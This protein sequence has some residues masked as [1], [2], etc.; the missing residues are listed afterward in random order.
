[1]KINKIF[2]IVLLAI[3]TATLA[4]A[5]N[6]KTL[7]GNITDEV[8]EPVI[9]AN[10]ILVDTK[11]GTISD[12]NGNFVLSNIPLESK[13]IRITYI[14]YVEQ[15]IDISAKTNIT[16]K[17]VPDQLQLNDFVVVG[18][19]SQKKAHVTGAIA[20][21]SPE[22]I[23][24]LSGPSLAMSLRGLVPGVSV[25][26]GDSRPGSMARVTIRNADLFGTS[27]SGFVPYNG[28]L[29]VIDGI[30]YDED[31][32]EQAF[33]NLDSDM[34]DNISIL[35]DGAAAV[36]GYR[37]ANGVILVNTKKGK[38]GAPK[39]SYS[40]QYGF[41]DEVSRTKRVNAYEYGVLSNAT[42]TANPKNNYDPLYDIFQADELEHMKTLNYDLVDKY[43]KAAATYRHSVN[44]TGATEAVNYF[45]GISYYTQ[46]GNIGKL[47][48][49]RWNYRA[50][51]DAKIGKGIKA[52]LQLTGD[53]GTKSSQYSKVSGETGENDYEY[54]F[55]HKLYIPEY[56][57]DGRPLSAS[58]DGYHFATIQDMN[59]FSHEFPQSMNINTALEYD[60][61]WI[62]TLKGLKMKVTYSKGI[63][64]NEGNQY[65]TDYD[66]YSFIALGGSGRHL[67]DSDDINISEGNVT[68]KKIS[69]GNR[70]RRTM[71]RSD[72]YQLS[73][74]AT[75]NRTF[76]LHELNGL[77]S[78]EK[79]ESEMENVDGQRINPYPYT[80]YQS[81]TAETE[82]QTSEF[83]RTESGTLA[84]L[85]RLNYANSNKYLAEFLFRVDASTK[86]APQNYYGKFWALSG[87]WIISEEDWFKNGKIGNTIDYFKIRGSY[88]LTGRDNIAA[89]KWLMT[90]NLEKDKGPIFGENTSTQSGNHIGVPDEAP[91]LDAHWS[92][93]HKLNIGIDGAVLKQRLSLGIDAY[94]NWD[95][96]IFNTRQGSADYPTTVG[97]Q[98]A[99]EN[100]GK[101][102]GWG[103]EISVSWKDRIGKDFKYNIG[104]NTGYSDHKDIEK[105][106]PSQFTFDQLLPGQWANTEGTWG[107]ECIGMFRSYQEIEEYFDKYQIVNYCGKTKENVHPGMLIYNNIRGSIKSDGTYY[108]PNDPE[109]PRAGYVDGNDRVKINN[110]SNT[111]GFNMNASGD[112][113][114]LAIRFQLGASWGG[115]REYPKATLSGTSPFLVDNM[116]VYQDVIDASGRVVVPQNL[117]AKYPNMAFSENNYSSTFW[118]LNG[119]NLTLNNITLSYS[120]P[121][122]FSN[123]MG[124]ASCRVNVTGQNILTL[125]NPFPDNF[126]NPMSGTYG[127]YPNLRRFTVGVNVSF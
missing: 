55:Q 67:Y 119:L 74:M 46:E 9:G 50:G 69:N 113:K 118:R 88:G 81:N 61:G 68:L 95:R 90:Y 19:G 54:L 33:N 86:F 36:Y 64:T 65:A 99:A 96:D 107:Y 35:K 15:T 48:Y 123:M 38:L 75:Y 112:W 56:L 127:Q 104:I 34:I 6:S 58:T 85:G 10:I 20:T 93:S 76:G 53:Y 124:I 52:S 40:G 28:P 101:M 18:Y 47:D 5:Q 109:D 8:G 39:I 84:Y 110:R 11:L 21:I 17:L 13:T 14:G 22:D 70:L 4:I 41:T 25:S 43:W 30:I 105:P 83:S 37:A 2:F 62:N 116:F 1:M 42:K 26:G 87:G 108:G 45:A 94:Y 103:V 100:Y 125:Y 98:A 91:N 49:S 57:S 7:T 121:K 59:N 79:A 16:V 44:V 97:A 29:Y 23:K 89:W 78:I 3:C 77:F 122:K 80:N 32:G 12:V 27:T 73:Y 117:D 92:K 31:K 111:Y 102:D 72:R 60:F 51:L 24:D 120:L 106:W 71:E 114:G 66:L 126:Y 115:Y 63:S 82:G